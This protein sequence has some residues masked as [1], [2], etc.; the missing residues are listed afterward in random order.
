V[1]VAGGAAPSTT[2]LRSGGKPS[3]CGMTARRLAGEPIF[4]RGRCGFGFIAGSFREEGCTGR[5][6]QRRGGG[7]GAAPPAGGGTGGVRAPAR[8]D[9]LVVT[10]ARTCASACSLTGRSFG[11]PLAAAR[12]AALRAAKPVCGGPKALGPGISAARR[13]TRR[14]G[15]PLDVAAQAAAVKSSA[16]TV[17]RSPFRPE[18]AVREARSPN[19]VP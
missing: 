17:P 9:Q 1:R 5:D 18:A 16:R 10:P 11:W 19:A 7:G 2:R 12:R 3:R 6:R 8:G 4:S 13:V 14:R 15:S